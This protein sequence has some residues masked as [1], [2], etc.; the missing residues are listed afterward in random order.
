M[1]DSLRLLR[2]RL[3]YSWIFLS[4]PPLISWLWVSSEEMKPSQTRRPSPSLRIPY[5]GQNIFSFLNSLIWSKKR[6]NRRR[7]NIKWVRTSCKFFV[8]TMPRDCK[9]DWEEEQAETRSLQGVRRLL[10]ND[11]EERLLGCWDR[12]KCSDLCLE[13]TLLPR[14]EKLLA[15]ELNPDKCLLEL[16]L[17]GEWE[18]CCLWQQ[19][20]LHS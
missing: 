10:L 1:T 4:C 12:V 15:A 13:L 8:L 18:S 7:E 5:K 2:I 16:G 9:E 20:S 3:V 14:E 11:D 6:L 17:I 19:S